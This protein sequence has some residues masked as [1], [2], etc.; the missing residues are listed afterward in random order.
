MNDFPRRLLTASALLCLL[1]SCQPEAHA[2]LGTD[3]DG[4][5]EILVYPLSVVELL[6]LVPAA[7]PQITPEST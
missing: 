5:P 2:Y 1:A 4:Q 7:A 6:P 3:A